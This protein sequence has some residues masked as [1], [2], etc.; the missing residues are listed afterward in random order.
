MRREGGQEREEEREGCLTVLLIS[1]RMEG[2]S[3][4][5][6]KSVPIM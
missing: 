3:S 5:F 6:L 1:L 4:I 2:L